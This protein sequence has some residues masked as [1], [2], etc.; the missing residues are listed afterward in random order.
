V[1][2]NRRRILLWT[3]GLAAAA[4]AFYLSVWTP[5]ARECRIHENE[6]AAISALSELVRAHLDYLQKHGPSA[7]K[8]PNLSALFLNCI[9]LPDEYARADAA[10]ADPVPH[11][12]YYL[13]VV[14]PKSEGEWLI[15]AY[16]EKYGETGRITWVQVY[17][18]HAWLLKGDTKGEP[19]RHASIMELRNGP[20][21]IAD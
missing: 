7:G 9:G 20:W 10:A 8:L 16:P 6:R 12:G 14:K 11:R 17:G 15:C 13:F 21:A 1:L 19:V 3:T 4:T 18:S 2:R 5:T